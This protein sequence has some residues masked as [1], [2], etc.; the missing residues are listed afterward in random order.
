[1]RSDPPAVVASVHRSARA[2][3]VIVLRL[4]LPAGHGWQS[5]ADPHR[6]GCA[7]PT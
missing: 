2:R 6:V 4:P 1:V 7:A 5:W 3:P